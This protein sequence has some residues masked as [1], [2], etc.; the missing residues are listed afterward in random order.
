VTNTDTILNLGW[1]VLCVGGILWHLWLVVGTHFY[2]T[3]PDFLEVFVDDPKIRVVLQP[4]GVFHPR[5][6]LFE[7]SRDDW[8]CI[9]GSP[10]FTGAAFSTNVE[11][12]LRFDSKVSRSNMH[13]DALRKVIDEHWESGKPLKKDQVEAYR[14]VWNRKT[15]MLGQLAG[16]YG[17]KAG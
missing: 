10:N 14:S 13:Y 15:Q 7:N 12:A 17:G 6:Y 2:Q 11:V 4:S 3:H 9:I 8:A 1:A 16:T 5:I